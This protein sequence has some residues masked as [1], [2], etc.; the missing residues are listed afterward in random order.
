MLAAKSSADIL[1]YTVDLSTA[2]A[3]TGD[4]IISAEILLPVHNERHPLSIVWKQISGMQIVFML[5][6]GQPRTIFR[7]GMEI[8][9]DQERRFVQPLQI[10]ITSASPAVDPPDPDAPVFPSDVTLNGSVLTA[11]T[12]NLPGGFASNG[13]AI[14]RLDPSIPIP[15][16]YASNG[17]LIVRAS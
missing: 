11:G 2:L 15:A 12:S 5:A 9:T 17:G 16:G 4:A 7:F 1:D 10:T 6:S 8:N 13:G 3:G 14:V